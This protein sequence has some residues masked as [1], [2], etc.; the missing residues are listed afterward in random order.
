ME[1]ENNEIEEKAEKKK[2]EQTKLSKQKQK[3]KLIKSRTKN[4][5]FNLI[6]FLLNNKNNFEEKLTPND[7]EIL[8]E[9]NSDISTIRKIKYKIKLIYGCFN[10]KRDKIKN[11]NL[12]KQF[13]VQMEMKD[14]YYSNN[15]ED[16][17]VD[18]YPEIKKGIKI[19]LSEFPFFYYDDINKEF[20]N[21]DKNEIK[22]EINCKDNEYIL[23]IYITYYDKKGKNN[24][25]LMLENIIDSDLFFKYFKNVFIIFQ[26]DNE[27]T[28]D[29][30][31][32]DEIIKKYLNNNNNLDNNKNKIFFLFNFLS[33]YKN[34]K[35]C[36]ENLINIFQENKN[37]ISD[38]DEDDEK[39]YFF[40]LDNDEKIV[41]IEPINSIGKTTTFLLMELKNNENSKDKTPYFSKKEKEEKV[42]LKEAKNLI[43]FIAEID[44]LNL[45]YIFDIKFRLSIVLYPNE[46]LTKIKLKKINFFR[47]NGT[48]KSKEYNYLKSCS[49]LLN[50][51][52]FSFNF[53]EIPS[54]DIE[55]DFSNMTCEKCKN[56]ISEDSYLYYCYICKMKYC[57]ECVQTQLK[58]NKGKKKYI[59]EKHHLIFFKTRD[60][61]QFLNLDQ[62]KLGKNKFADCNEDDLRYWS[63][64]RC[65]GCRNS[66]REGLERYLCL[67]CKKGIRVADG[68][69]DFCS[70]CIDKMCKNKNDRII[71]EN[72]SNGIVDDYN[73]YFF[74]DYKF[75]IEH[76]HDNHIYLM[77]PY[78]YDG[79]YIF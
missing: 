6:S 22:K 28:F 42:Q 2:S 47:F 34:N 16:V 63:S 51:P 60:K 35:N 78:Q 71:L 49:D 24:P 20:K 62:E 7:M 31:S 59:D 25:I 72:K 46:E 12:Y 57:Y 50:L 61:N 10:P 54:V 53:S 52:S 38:F 43:H 55:I 4:Y 36:D 44:K 26:L 3:N 9:T 13:P 39:N 79:Y 68:Y 56:I 41:E 19:Y 73:N 5:L 67:N 58:N 70:E 21:I 65:N 15:F 11:I 76:K 14:E 1:S 66:F 74:D 33:S 69:I 27:K 64:T 17:T 75:K 18:I 32:K 23:C 48:F 8:L 37:I 40:I 45:D 29:K 77:M 30:F